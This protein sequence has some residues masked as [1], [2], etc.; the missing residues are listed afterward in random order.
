MTTVYVYCIGCGEF[1]GDDMESKP[2]H[3]CQFPDDDD[4]CGHC[5][6]ELKDTG[7]CDTHHREED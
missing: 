6:A 2:K 1:F 4:F 7:S 5:G 3:V